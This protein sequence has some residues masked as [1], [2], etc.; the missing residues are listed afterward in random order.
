MV[1]KI[2]LLPFAFLTLGLWP[3]KDCCPLCQ[4]CWGGCAPPLPERTM[5]GHSS[6]IFPFCSACFAPRLSLEEVFSD[7]G[8][9]GAF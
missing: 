6:V 2:I 9:Q 3:S 8:T 4:L 7:M 5:M 1:K